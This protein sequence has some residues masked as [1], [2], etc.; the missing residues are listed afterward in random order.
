MRAWLP[1][2]LIGLMAPAAGCAGESEGAAEGGAEDRFVLRTQTATV[3]V[4]RPTSNSMYAILE[5]AVSV[6]D[7]CLGVDDNVLI[8][9]PGT[10]V[11]RRD[12]LV[13]E[14]PHL[15]KFQVGDHVR[16][17][18]GYIQEMPGSPANLKN[19]HLGLTVPSDCAKD[20]IWLAGPAS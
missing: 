7:G 9:P 16:L 6:E 5:G 15:G 2:L 19:G 1:L 20:S 18:G 13:I 3:L 12:P 11:A 14:V 10:T 8:W 4:S 17:A